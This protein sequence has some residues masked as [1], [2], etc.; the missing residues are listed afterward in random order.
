MVLDVYRED[1][2][3]IGDAISRMLTRD[4]ANTF[5]AWGQ[6][7]AVLMSRHPRLGAI[8]EAPSARTAANETYLALVG[9]TRGILELASRR[10]HLSEKLSAEDVLMLLSA[11]WGLESGDKRKEEEASVLQV[12]VELVFDVSA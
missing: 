2:E 12:I 4:P 10:N 9:I 11:T 6:E 5:R 7:L 3:E 8:C 1:V